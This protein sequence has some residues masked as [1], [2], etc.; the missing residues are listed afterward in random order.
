MTKTTSFFWKF[1]RDGDYSKT[2][3]AFIMD[4]HDFNI[5]N[6]NGKIFWITSFN[7]LA[8]ILILLQDVEIYNEK[9]GEKRAG[10]EKNTYVSAVNDC[11]FSPPKKHIEL[12]HITSLVLGT[13][14]MGKHKG[15]PL[16]WGFYED[17]CEDLI[18]IDVT[19]FTPVRH[20]GAKTGIHPKSNNKDL[21]LCYRNNVFF[22][23]K[24]WYW[25]LMPR[26]IHMKRIVDNM[27]NISEKKTSEFL[28]K[29]LGWKKN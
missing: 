22:N 17:N 21:L 5:L 2:Y 29:I 19:D 18:K 24:G 28:D 4:V 7:C 8:N 16:D 26:H 6:Q 10:L 1:T 15:F 14:I 3:V 25:D 27:N 13:A 11:G 12:R 9:L 23:N 20:V